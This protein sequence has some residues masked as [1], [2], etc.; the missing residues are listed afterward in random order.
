MQKYWDSSEFR[1]YNYKKWH[2]IFK[3]VV[4]DT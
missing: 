1:L 2:K 3:T 4:F